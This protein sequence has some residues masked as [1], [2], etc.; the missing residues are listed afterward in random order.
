M[1]VDYWHGILED[2]VTSPSIVLN[3]V[4]CLAITISKISTLVMKWVCVAYKVTLI[5]NIPY[6]LEGM[7]IG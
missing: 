2:L 4:S 7:L 1:I 6:Y 5:N 3:S